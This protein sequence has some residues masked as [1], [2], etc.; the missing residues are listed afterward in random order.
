M[1]IPLFLAFLLAALPSWAS[2]T[3]VLVQTTATS[4]PAVSFQKFIAV[5]NLGPNDI[6]CA[7]SSAGAVVNKAWRVAAN[8]GVLTVTGGYALWC[9][10]ATANQATGAATIVLRLN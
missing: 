7:D 6:F 2:T 1:R 8:G 9:M 4:I 3:E 10:A 5:Q